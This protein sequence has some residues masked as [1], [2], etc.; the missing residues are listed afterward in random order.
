MPDLTVF[1]TESCYSYARYIS[2]VYKID[3]DGNMLVYRDISQFEVDPNE[4]LEPCDFDKAE[5]SRF[6]WIPFDATYTGPHGEKV[7]CIQIYE[8]E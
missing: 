8:E 3:K 4:N 1:V 2:K 5:Y 7:P 6:V